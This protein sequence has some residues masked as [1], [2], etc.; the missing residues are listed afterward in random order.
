MPMKHDSLKS[1]IYLNTVFSTG[2]ANDRGA[3]YVMSFQGSIHRS[4]Q[5]GIFQTYFGANLSMGSYHVA[6]YYNLNHHYYFNGGNGNPY[7]MDSS[8]HIPASGNFFGSYGVSG[9]INIVAPHEHI[10]KYR[11]SEWR[12]LGLE[13]S[14][15][16]EFGKYADLRNQL[17]DSAANVIFRKQF[18]SYLGLY[19]E[20]LWTNRVQAEFGFKMAAG[21]DLSPGSHYSSY[22][23]SSI[24][25]L[26][27]FSIAYH[28]KKDH[29][30]GFMQINFGTYADNIQFGLTYRLGKR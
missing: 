8:N 26:Y 4:Q 15:Q 28:I 25:P 30:T 24:L 19:T 13:T 5:F 17:A 29:V 6:D 10:R 20:W 11:H 1:A 12:A 16:W 22:Y 2:S 21:M 18:S 14:L 27:V 9:G 23:A 3:D 7:T